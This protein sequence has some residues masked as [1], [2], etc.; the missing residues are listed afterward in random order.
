MTS[1]VAEQLGLA[2]EREECLAAKL[3]VAKTL[4]RTHGVELPDNLVEDEYDTLRETLGFDPPEVEAFSRR[5]RRRLESLRN[6]TIEEDNNQDEDDGDEE[7][8]DETLAHE[9]AYE[10]EEELQDQAVLAE[11]FNMRFQPTTDTCDTGGNPSK[12][13]DEAL[14]PLCKGSRVSKLTAILMLSNLQQK[15]NVSNSFMDSL[16]ALLAKELLPTGNALPDSHRSARKMMS[17][18]G[19]D[20]HMA[21]RGQIWT[22]NPLAHRIVEFV[23]HFC[24]NAE[25]RVMML[26]RFRETCHI[27]ARWSRF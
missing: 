9:E 25:P 4:L 19:L 21:S 22:F 3:E 15:Y 5:A 13:D 24:K 14:T 18:I 2:R 11:F 27:L 1:W 8:L 16:Y 6:T 10:P 17:S 12:L 23:R 20:Y 26:L 7:P